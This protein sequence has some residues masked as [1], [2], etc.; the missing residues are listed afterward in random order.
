MLIH[1][2]AQQNFEGFT[3]VERPSAGRSIEK[4]NN[5]ASQ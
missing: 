2:S 1:I 5:R 3:T 4:L